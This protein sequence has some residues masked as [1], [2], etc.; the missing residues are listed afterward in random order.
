MGKHDDYG[1]ELLGRL[2]GERWDPHTQLRSIDEGGVRADLDGVIWSK[3]RGKIE[4]AVEIEA[5]VYK[6]IR[7]AIV[8]LALHGAPKKLLIVIRAQ[9]QLGSDEQI[10]RH[11]QHIWEE[12]ACERHGEFLVLCLTGTGAFPM[13]EEDM[14][15][16]ASSLSVMNVL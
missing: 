8:D 5:K 12:I 2:L 11:C 9:P 1:K 3:T 10:K 7:G 4:C 14:N 6:Q 13:Y 16:I 15:L